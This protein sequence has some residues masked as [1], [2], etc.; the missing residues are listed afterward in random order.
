MHE[1]SKGECGNEKG[2]RCSQADGCTK[3]LKEQ[4]LS[5]KKETATPKRSQISTQDADTHVS[6]RLSHLETSV[7]LF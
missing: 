2:E 3:L 6:V 7:T 4:N 1:G 5:C